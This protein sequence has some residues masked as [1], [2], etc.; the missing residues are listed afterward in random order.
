MKFAIIT[1]SYGPD[2]E[3]AELL[4]NSVKELVSADVEHLLLVDR[5][6]VPQFNVLR[7]PRTRVLEVESIL[8]WWIRR[9]PGARRWW[10]S[11]K[12]LPI[13]N[14]ILQQVVKLSVGEHIDADNY[15]FVDSD[16]SFIRPFNP[17]EFVDS[18]NNLRLFRVPNAA[19][20]ESHFRWHRTAARLLGLPSTDYFGAN[21]IG[22]IIS[23]RRDVLTQL[24]RHIEKSTGRSWKS[25]VCSSLHLSEYILYGI[26]VEHVLK[27]AGHYYQEQAHC[28][29]SWDYDVSTQAGLDQF[30]AETRPEHVAVMVSSKDCISP[31][32]YQ[33]SLRQISRGLQLI[34]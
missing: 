4:A 19:R 18:E 28:H 13:R 29:I 12:T 1:P 9:M 8:P 30:I 20:Q 17:N 26:F 16:V 24:Y 32:Q 31:K 11:L 27:G 6:D 14:W 25:A 21:Y 3:R 10:L 34:S 22:N 2:F 23:W 33:E 7:G 5:R 15:L